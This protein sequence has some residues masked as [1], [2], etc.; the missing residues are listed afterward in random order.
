MHKQKGLTLLETT[1]ALTLMAG[2]MTGLFVL[3]RSQQET[4]TTVVSEFKGAR[5]SM[6][7]LALIGQ[8]LSNA[9]TVSAIATSSVRYTAISDGSTR[10]IS[11][12]PAIPS[13]PRNRPLRLDL[14]D[15]KGPLPISSQ[16][17]FQNH[18]PSRIP[19]RLRDGTTITTTVP[20]FVFRDGTGAPTLLPAA[21]RQIEIYLVLQP[22]PDAPPRYV[23]TSV[24]LR[25]P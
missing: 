15:G 16:R 5:Q 17:L 18:N 13:D 24:Y 20:I 2:F 11:L 7:P 14:G 12:A 9:A 8:E 4:V 10:T 23:S 25:N 21:V 3:F 1:L 6:Q 22:K 19:L